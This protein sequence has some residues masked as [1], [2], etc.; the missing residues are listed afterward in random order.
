MYGVTALISCACDSDSNNVLSW[1]ELSDEVCIDRQRG[2]FHGQNI[3]LEG[4]QYQDTNN[5]LEI[6]VEEAENALKPLFE[7]GENFQKF[8]FGEENCKFL[9]VGIYIETIKNFHKSKI[10][11]LKNDIF[12]L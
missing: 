9:S 5:D 1:Q 11:G 3:V 6:T 8:F 10:D 7:S 12:V 2:F 4:F